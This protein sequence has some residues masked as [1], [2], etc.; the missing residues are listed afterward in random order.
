MAT[1]NERRIAKNTLFLYIRMLLTMGISLYTSRVVL[2]VLGVRDY[3]VYNVVGGLIV[4]LSFLN[5]TMSGATQRFLN[6][7][8]GRGEQGRLRETFSAAWSIHASIALILL[9]LGE[10]AGL[11][12]V[13]TQLVIDPERM[14]AANWT[15]QFSLVGGISTVLL[16]PFNGAVFAHEKMNI[17]AVFTI[18]FSLLKLGVALV[19]L[20]F[21]TADNLIVY[22]ALMM[23]ASLAH[24]M[25]YMIYGLRHFPECSMRLRPDREAV[26]SMLRYSGS[27]LIGT[28]CCTVETQGVLVILNRVGGTVLNAAGGLT[29]T[30]VLSISQ[31]GNSIV[32]AFRPQIIKQY[33]AGDYDTVQRLMCNC[34]KYAIL[35]LALVSIPAYVEM[36]Y[37]LGLWLKEVP[38]YTVVFC[39]LTLFMTLSQMSVLTLNAGMHATG[40]IFRFST[41][42]GLSYILELPLMYLM[43]RL[44]GHPEWAYY[45]PIAQMAFLVGLICYMFRNRMRTFS[46]RRY[47]LSAYL[48]PVALSLAAGA[49]TWCLT[50][51]MDDGFVRLLAV[52]ATSTVL[53]PSLAW[54]LLLTP[55]MRAEVLQAVKKKL[56]RA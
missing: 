12:F 14:T 24:F 5:G 52:G 54:A 16:V 20:F 23:A 25:M 3:G 33:A 10:T 11:W 26:R 32:M 39:R 15:Y 44:T 34:S 50:Y 40:D 30:V 1:A 49:A 4:I 21:A 42:T 56:H 2:D 17:Y 47:V 18:I 28:L 36:P 37:L 51:V 6:F 41:F 53:L 7:E 27:D 38:E 13:N 9:V 22:A 8:M 29:M 19:L 46:I 45:L 48:A 43:I 35:L 31:F 55:D